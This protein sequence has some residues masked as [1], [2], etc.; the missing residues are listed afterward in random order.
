MPYDEDNIKVREGTEIC[1]SLGAMMVQD[2]DMMMK[3]LLGG[4]PP[5]LVYVEY[6]L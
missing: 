2:L 3:L 1:I 4:L 5:G 6:V